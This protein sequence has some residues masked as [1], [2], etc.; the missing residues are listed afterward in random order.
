M[1]NLTG[2]NGNS[3]KS[4][5]LIEERDA[6][7][8]WT[9]GWVLDSINATLRYITVP[10]DHFEWYEAKRVS[11][12]MKLVAGRAFF[13]QIAGEATDIMFEA[14]NRAQL[15]PALRAA[16]ND[17][18][19]DIETGI[20][21]SSETMQDEVNFW[22][23]DGLTNDYEYNADYPKT[24]NT[25]NFNIYGVHTNGDLSWV[26][27][28]PEFAKE[29]MPIGYQVPA[30]GTYMLSV[31]EDYYSED[32]A[33]LYVT[34]HEKSPE[35]TVDL[36]SN[37]YEFSVNQAETNNTRFTVALRLKLDDDGTITGLENIGAD[38][39]SLMKFIYQDKMYI[40]HHGVIYDATGKRVT[41]INK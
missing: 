14:A 39:D 8:N 26:A 10:S 23:S 15:M 24:L 40:L 21:L 36:M 34:D 41:T 6:N 2:L 32:L 12:D 16:H 18:P 31:S 33:A 22:I 7:G 28:G 19:V 25:T 35:L 13:V 27:T 5:Q 4:G 30:A 37:P 11:K 20:V 1:V 9:G 38:N 3:L 29:S 17:E